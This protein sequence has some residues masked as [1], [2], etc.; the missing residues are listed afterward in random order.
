MKRATE[1]RAIKLRPA[2]INFFYEVREGLQWEYPNSISH[3]F[4]Y[5][6]FVKKKW[7]NIILSFRDGEL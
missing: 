5:D 3:R 2:C 7:G 1:Q 6:S 4:S